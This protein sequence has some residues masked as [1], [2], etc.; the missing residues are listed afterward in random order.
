MNTK[1]SHHYKQE[2]ADFHADDVPEFKLNVIVNKN[3]QL[4]Q[5]V[6]PTPPKTEVV[7]HCFDK[8][9]QRIKQKR[10]ENDWKNNRF[11]LIPKIQDCGAS[12]EKMPKTNK[13]KSKSPQRGTS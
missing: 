4:D 9:H 3:L 6:W 8:V 7:K 10:L 12:I 5:H 11:H 1:L 2:I 13:K